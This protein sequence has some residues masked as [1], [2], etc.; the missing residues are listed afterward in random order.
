[1]HGG[2]FACPGF[3][4]FPGAGRGGAAFPVMRAVRILK[5]VRWS[6]FPCFRG[7]PFP[8]FYGKALTLFF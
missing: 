4:Y 6:V 8:G 7:R 2:F 5:P 1:M 3:L